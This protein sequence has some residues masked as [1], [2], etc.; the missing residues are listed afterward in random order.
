MRT[1]NATNGDVWGHIVKYFQISL[2]DD[3]AEDVKVKRS[4][5]LSIAL[6]RSGLTTIAVSELWR[7]ITTLEPIINAFNPPPFRVSSPA[8][9]CKRDKFSEYWVRINNDLPTLPHSFT[10]NRK[11]LKDQNT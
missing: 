7:S 10:L 9:E 2:S 4:T 6:V 8:F 1:C 5:L 11:W 3:S